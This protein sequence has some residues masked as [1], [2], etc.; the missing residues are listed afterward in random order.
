MIKVNFN[1][2]SKE[3]ELGEWQDWIRRGEIAA[4]ELLRKFKAGEEIKISEVLYKETRLLI[5]E[6]FHGKCA[7]CEAQFVLDQRGDV[8]HFRPKGRIT[9]DTN[10]PLRVR[11]S[12]GVERNHPGYFWLAYDWR[13][14]LPAC[15]RCNRPGKYDDEEGTLRQVGKWDRFPV[16][17]NDYALTPEEVAREQPMLLNPLLNNPDEHFEFDPATGRLVLKTPEARECD[18]I[19]D[20]NREGLPEKRREVY[21]SVLAQIGAAKKAADE[22]K[23]A[24]LNTYLGLVLK[25]KQGKAEY[26][27]AGRCALEEHEPALQGWMADLQA[28]IALAQTLATA[29]QHAGTAGG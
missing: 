28:R 24:D 21:L 14:L 18:R 20:L 27:I 16:R 29:L 4:K 2:P 15:S 17:N 12:A 9:D 13:N 5:F 7:Y 19:L 22:L 23:P 6:G 11:D 25:H 3:P 26:S 8:D 10:K 1:G